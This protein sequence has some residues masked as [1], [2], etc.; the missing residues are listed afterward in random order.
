MLYK[1]AYYY[2]VIVC[3]GMLQL[4]TVRHLCRLQFHE[5]TRNNLIC[6]CSGSNSSTGIVIFS[7]IG[8]NYNEK[9]TEGEGAGM[10]S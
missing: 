3:L 10:P 6:D 4:C 2:P 7:I 1:V 5:K 9:E 8:V